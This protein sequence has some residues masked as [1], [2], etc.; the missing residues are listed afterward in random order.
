MSSTNKTANLGLNQW[1]A[2]DAVE[3]ADFNL[4]NQLIEAAMGRRLEWELVRDVTPEKSVNS[5][6]MDLSDLDFNNY[7]M[8]A[9]SFDSTPGITCHLNKTTTS[10]G[11]VVDGSVILHFP[12][13][14]ASR[15]ICS[16]IVTSN[17]SPLLNEKYSE[18]KGL[19]FTGGSTI[20]K[21]AKIRIW[22]VK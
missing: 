16:C 8:L 11:I 14:D 18:M 3:M 13:R 12:L 15:R 19:T 21:T 2:S 4:D 1:V 5:I 10:M 9:I 22:G 20:T 6:Y 7:L 17:S